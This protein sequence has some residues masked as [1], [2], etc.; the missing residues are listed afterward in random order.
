MIRSSIKSGEHHRPLGNWNRARRK[1]LRIA[2]KLGRPIDTK[3][4]KAVAALLVFGF[5]TTA[6]CQG[7]LNRG[8]PFPWID[9]GV[10]SGKSR[11]PS[12]SKRRLGQRIRRNL[13]SELHMLE[14]LTS[15]Y[16]RR[17]VPLEQRLIVLPF[18][19]YG[20][21]QLTVQGGHVQ[22]VVPK[23]LRTRRLKSFQREITDF[24]TFLRKKYD[25]V[26]AQSS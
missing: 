2:D 16:A 17:S 20:A 11:S 15:F 1:V 13:Q 26:A 8:E 9:V 3:L 19:I 25:S 10:Y 24:V 14:L 21:W 12:L 18:G 7:H 22:Y 4:Q 6:S 5:E 23:L